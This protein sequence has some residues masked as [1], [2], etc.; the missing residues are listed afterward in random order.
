MNN[1]TTQNNNT[2]WALIEVQPNQQLKFKKAQK[3][4]PADSKGRTWKTTNARE[5]ARFVNTSKLVIK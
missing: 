4:V 3:L 5:L 2:F 1:S